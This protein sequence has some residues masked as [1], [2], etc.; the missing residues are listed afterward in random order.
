M[1]KQIRCVHV[2]ELPSRN[3]S[4]IFH[5]QNRIYEEKIVSNLSF[6]EL[7]LTNKVAVLVNRKLT[8]KFFI[9]KILY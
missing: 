6:N 8:E 4:I 9:T 3:K 7:F 1:D 2:H 5:C